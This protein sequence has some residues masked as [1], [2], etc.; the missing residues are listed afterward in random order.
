M[1]PLLKLKD[2]VSEPVRWQR[3]CWR[4]STSS[5]AGWSVIPPS[6][7]AGNC[8][9]SAS[10]GPWRPGVKYLLC[11]EI[12]AMLDPITQAQIWGLILAEA[13]RRKLGLLIVSHDSTLLDRLC[14]RIQSL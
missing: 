4:P 9:G 14:T 12:T 10:P 6:C 7:P 3:N 8:S 5:P 1:D 13:E 11:D 2:S